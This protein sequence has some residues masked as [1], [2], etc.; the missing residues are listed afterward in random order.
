M[1]ER[2]ETPPVASDDISAHTYRAVCFDLDGTLLPMRLEDFFGAYFAALNGFISARGLDTETFT[3]GLK[4]GIKAMMT[5]DDTRINAEVY[6]EA[7]YEQVDIHAVDWPSLFED[8]YEHEF[9]KI[10]AAVRPNPAAARAVNTLSAKGYPLMLTTMPM[11]PRR[12][13]EWRLIWA[14][15]DPARFARLTSF[16]NSTS[17][18][19]ELTYYAENLAASGLAGHEVLM[20]GNNTVEDLAFIDLGARAFL[21]TDYLLDPVGYDLSTVDHGSMEEFAGRVGTLPICAKPAATIDDGVIAHEATAAALTL[22]ASAPISTAP[23]KDSTIS[24]FSQAASPDDA[25]RTASVSDGMEF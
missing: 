12:A 19:P 3:T 11:F 6:W 17:V 10:G 4:A 16:E 13:V 22:N 7:F 18:K 23:A 14:G 2:I 9:G 20:V 25:P 8:F 5:H 1:E 21:V 24:I 15:I